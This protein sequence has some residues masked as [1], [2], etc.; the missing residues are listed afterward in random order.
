VPDPL[1]ALQ[2]AI[3]AG[4]PAAAR[5]VLSDHPD[6]KAAAL[7]RP[8]PHGA[9]G[10][11]AMLA[12][13]QRGNLAIVD[14][15]L[16]AGADINA[17]SHWWAGGFGVLDE[18]PPSLAA[19]LI[20]RGARLTAHAA[21]RLGLPDELR[22]IVDADPDTVH[23]RGGDGQTPLHFAS[24]I[25]IADLL[26]A[27]GADIDAI[28]VDHESTPAQWMLGD[29][30]DGGYPRSRR[31]VARFLVARGCRTD[32]LM[33]AALGDL[34]RV[35]EHLDGD[36]SSIRV[37]VSERWFPKRD[38]RAG[39][40]IYIW[41]LGANATPHLVA[42]RFGHEDVVAVLL[43]RSPADVKLAAACEL[44]DEA[45]ADSLLA[46][47]PDAVRSL[48]VEDTRRLADAAQSGN[49]T[50]VRL[51]LKA[52]W[53]VD[54]RGQH[55]GTALHWAGFHGD[56]AMTREIL[57]HR[58]PLEARSTEFEGTPLEWTLY[59]SSQDAGRSSEYVATLEAQL[60]AGAAVPADPGSM[61]D[62]VRELLRRYNRR[63]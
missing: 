62:P 38:P 21:A 14:L 11:T 27:R 13:V 7:D 17:R 40:T 50:A 36:A 16:G 53:P 63:G 1:D 5:A 6:L 52:G 44:G 57:A 26:L 41:T 35:N 45:L 2:A 42:R 56:A 46:A 28:D 15:L 60:E 25:E 4:D 10:G 34:R 55:G 30:V 58:P 18:A 43:E 12:A 31:D 3:H 8:L 48:T 9:F 32:I 20:E 22:A 33:A 59:G 39:G 47:E 23:T 49:R 54:A 37:S 19:A 51:M 24:T 29:V 61:S